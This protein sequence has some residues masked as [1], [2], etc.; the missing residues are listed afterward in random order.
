MSFHNWNVQFFI[1][2]YLTK[3]EAGHK[4]DSIT[5][6]KIWSIIDFPRI[7]CLSYPQCLPLLLITKVRTLNI[8]QNTWHIIDGAMCYNGTLCIYSNN[9]C[10]LTTFSRILLTNLNKKILPIKPSILICLYPVFI[11]W[12]KCSKNQVVKLQCWNSVQANGNIAKVCINISL[13]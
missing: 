13:A 7:I 11:D 5:I 2:L 4:A 9:S 12:L 10:Q 3:G 6:K 1:K 8:W